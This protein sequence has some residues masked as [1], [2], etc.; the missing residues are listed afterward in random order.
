MPPSVSCPQQCGGLF[1]RRGAPC[2]TGTCLVGKPGLPLSMPIRPNCHSTLPR[3]CPRSNGAH[4][5]PGRPCH[6]LL[7]PSSVLHAPGRVRQLSSAAAPFRDWQDGQ[8]AANQSGGP[9]KLHPEFGN[10]LLTGIGMAIGSPRRAELTGGE[11]GLQGANRRAGG[12]QARAGVTAAASRLR[13][14]V[15]RC[16]PG[17]PSN[18]IRLG[19]SASWPTGCIGLMYCGYLSFLHCWCGDARGG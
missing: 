11:C 7:P 18:G 4:R 15:S 3:S 5:F 1:A 14:F 2:A 9:T 12:R 8:S 10:G 19:R 13:G 17:V 16:R 6:E